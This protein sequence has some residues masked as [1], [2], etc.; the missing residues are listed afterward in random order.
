MAEF[1]Y[2]T[3]V[4]SGMLGSCRDWRHWL[5]NL[6]DISGLQ[7][8]TGCHWMAFCRRRDLPIE[9]AI[10][11]QMPAPGSIPSR[12]SPDDVM[13]T[14]KRNMSDQALMQAPVLMLHAGA[15]AHL[16]AGPATWERRKDIDTS[17]VDRLCANALP[18]RRRPVLA[19]VG[20]GSARAGGSST[21]TGHPHTPIRHSGARG[22][23]HWT[24]VR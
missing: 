4:R 5:T 24:S 16:Q 18:G 19:T 3:P 22:G 10:H 8:I 12:S 13:L 6:D 21:S 20:C 9:C 15:S 2:P 23:G 14:L 7:G 1:L 17:A 11:M